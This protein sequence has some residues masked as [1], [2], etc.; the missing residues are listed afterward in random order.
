MKSV[1]NTFRSMP[2]VMKNITLLNLIG[3]VFFVVAPF[4]PFMPFYVNGAAVSQSEF[5]RMGAG[6]IS[7]IL[8]IVMVI[9]GIGLI[10][11][12]NWAR[13][14]TFGL[15]ATVGCYG[16]MSSLTMGGKDGIPVA[17]KAV[18]ISAMMINIVF[19]YVYLFRFNSVKNFFAKKA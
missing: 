1:V 8:G 5:W 10:N 12:R 9:A 2:R 18:V 16:F 15:L 11:K 17:P 19:L 3:G 6:L 4:I 13:I 7:V 14:L